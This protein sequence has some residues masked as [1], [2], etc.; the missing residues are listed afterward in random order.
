MTFCHF[1][2]IEY[3]TP[4]FEPVVGFIPATIAKVAPGCVDLSF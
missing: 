2:N 3:Q 4:N 1:V